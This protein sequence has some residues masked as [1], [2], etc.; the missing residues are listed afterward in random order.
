MQ[1]CA[2]ETH[3][4]NNK[5]TKLSTSLGPGP[6]CQVSEEENLIKCTKSKAKCKVKKIQRI[7]LPLH[8]LRAQSFAPILACC[9]YHVCAVLIPLPSCV[10]LSVSVC[11]VTCCSKNEEPDVVYGT[12]TVFGECKKTHTTQRAAAT[13]PGVVFR[14]RINLRDTVR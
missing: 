1:R 9:V 12:G 14:F 8:Q 2:C 4:N 10:C 13:L 7:C 3:A 11:V 6:A 5:Y